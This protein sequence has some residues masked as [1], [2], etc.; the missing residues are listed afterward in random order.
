MKSSNWIMCKHISCCGTPMR[1]QNWWVNSQIRIIRSSLIN[2]T[3]TP[4]PSST[5]S[6]LVY[7]VLRRFPFYLPL[8]KS[9]VLSLD[10]RRRRPNLIHLAHQPRY[11]PPF[12]AILN[13]INTNLIH[14]GIKIWIWF[15][16]IYQRFD[17]ITK[18]YL[19]DQ[20]PLRHSRGFP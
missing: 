2:S 19:I 8:I 10:G 14:L 9:W 11:I 13:S 3:S 7:T 12:Q 6:A 16:I 15:R 5:A 18:P 4:Q 20:C 17:Q 1:D